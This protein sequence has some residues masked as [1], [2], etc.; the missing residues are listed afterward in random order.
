MPHPMPSLMSPTL[1]NNFSNYL[2]RKMITPPPPPPSGDA[3]PSMIS[4]SR[5]LSSTESPRRRKGI[6]SSPRSVSSST[7]ASFPFKGMAITPRVLLDTTI[8]RQSSIRSIASNTANNNILQ[9]MAV[10]A[11][12]P[13]IRARARLANTKKACASC[14]CRDQKLVR[15]W[16]EIDHLKGIVKDLLVMSLEDKD[17]DENDDD[18]SLEDLPGLME[19]PTRTRSTK[20]DLFQVS[21]L[22]LTPGPHSFEEDSEDPLKFSTVSSSSA[23]V[24]M[25]HSLR[26]KQ[27]FTRGSP[28]KKPKN[29]RHLRIQVNGKWGYYSGPVPQKDVPLV[30]CVLRFDNGDLYLG[31]ME[32]SCLHGPGSYYPKG[33]PKG[34]SQVLRGNF[35]WN[36]LS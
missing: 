33:Y 11:E 28:T 16:K 4:L 19:S 9:P 13:K 3:S 14:V 32:N 20:G 21:E 36:E 29:I 15:Q 18:D 6:P 8:T 30:G 26:I 2:S 22:A 10:T 24:Q 34:G 12:S 23:M 31:N 5:F 17:K 7:S 1:T 27:S 35:A 25:S